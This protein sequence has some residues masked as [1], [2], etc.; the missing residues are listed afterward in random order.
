MKGRPGS[1]TSLPG[2][3]GCGSPSLRPFFTVGVA[4]VIILTLQTTEA[5][6]QNADGRPYRPVL[7]AGPTTMIGDFGQGNFSE[8]GV[9]ARAGL[10]LAQTEAALSWGRW[11]DVGRFGYQSIQLEL[12]LPLVQAA[13]SALHV[14]FGVGATNIADT[15]SGAQPE[16]VGNHA[17]AAYGFGLDVKPNSWL[18]LRGDV[19]I[20]SDGGAWNG[21]WRV[22]G[23]YAPRPHALAT[24]MSSRFDAAI[25]WLN[26]MAGP[27][28]SVEPAYSLRLSHSLAE[29][30]SLSLG[31]QLIH[32]EIPNA[33]RPAG[34]VWDTRSFLGVPALEWGPPGA[35]FL[36]LR[37]GPAF[38]SMGEGPDAG[39]TAGA[40]VSVDLK[41]RGIVALPFTIGGGW[42]WL[43]REGGAGSESA[44]GADQHDVLLTVAL[45]L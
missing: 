24:N 35:P 20:R 21:A 6:A 1:R 7:M 19:F 18:G 34:Y 13:S 36:A 11:P 45:S 33:D 29:C 8:L 39:V 23:G 38:A 10:A 15:G 9:V 41:L 32:W 44:T 2:A 4:I 3:I 12:T 22:L 27:W 30:L 28:R 37:A 16:A 17:S 42:L 5:R 14:V 25:S 31:V 26:A 43:A 40:N